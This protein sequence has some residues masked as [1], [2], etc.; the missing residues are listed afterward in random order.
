M[1]TP[2][3]VERAREL[4]RLVRLAPVRQVAAEREYVRRLRHLAEQ[5][6]QR[7]SVAHAA[8]MDVGQRRHPHHTWSFRHRATIQQSPVTSER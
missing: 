5:R 8:E 2:T 1:G 6:L 7:R 4:P 3:D